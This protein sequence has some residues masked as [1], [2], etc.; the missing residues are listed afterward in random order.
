MPLIINLPRTASS[1]RS[2]RSRADALR[3]S[4]LTL[5]LLAFC[6]AQIREIKKHSLGA[7]KLEGLVTVLDTEVI[8]GR[9]VVGVACRLR[10]YNVLFFR[11]FLKM[12]GNTVDHLSETLCR[13]SFKS[14]FSTY[15]QH[16]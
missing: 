5:N 3:L 6:W 9:R 8:L 11:F 4:A 10:E 14:L 7:V 12:F 13:K 1:S 15:K 2:R 16:G